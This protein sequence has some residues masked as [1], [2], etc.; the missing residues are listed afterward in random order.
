[1]EKR[2]LLQPIFPNAH[3]PFLFRAAKS[4]TLLCAFFSGNGEG[5]SRCAIVVSR[6]ERIVDGES[7][8]SIP[9]V[10]SVET[11]GGGCLLLAAD[12]HCATYRVSRQPDP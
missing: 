12:R 6:F 1:M 5:T 10:A 8:W 11:G 2:S 9:I 7:Q 4:G 3:A